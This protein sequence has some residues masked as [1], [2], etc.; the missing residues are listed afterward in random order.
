M[1]AEIFVTA[2]ELYDVPKLVKGAISM[3]DRKR[4]SRMK[5]SKYSN[6]FF[7]YLYTNDGESPEEHD[8][9]VKRN[10]E[11]AS[12]ANDMHVKLSVP[13]LLFTFAVLHCIY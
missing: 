4:R 9:V 6:D 5:N 3:A 11:A 1:N 13:L 8:K 10:A 7:K 2:K 12:K